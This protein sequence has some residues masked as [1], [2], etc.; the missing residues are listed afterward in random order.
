[1][2]IFG[3]ATSATSRSQLE[4]GFSF[5]RNHLNG[6]DKALIA[7][8]SW[9]RASSGYNDLSALFDEMA[10]D[11][12]PGLPGE[13]PMTIVVSAGN[14]GASN[15]LC[16]GN[17]IERT[18][19]EPAT[20]KNVIAVGATENYRPIG[21]AGQPPVGCG[22][23]CSVL[24][25]DATDIER[26]AH[27]SAKGV[28]FESYEAGDPPLNTPQ[29]AHNV[30]IKPDLV[31]P[32]VRIVSTVPYATP[33]TFNC[34]S[35]L[36]ETT[37]GYS[38][39]TF[40]SYGQ[41]TSF[42]APAVAGGAAL[43]RKWFLDRGTDAAPSLIKAALIATADDLCNPHQHNASLDCANGVGDHRPSN[44]HG[45]GRINVDT[46]TDPAVPRFWVNESAALAVSTGQQRSFTVTVDDEAKDVYVV[47]AWS[48]K[49]SMAG[50]G[51]QSGLI[52]DLRLAID[53]GNSSAFWRGNNFNENKGA[54]DDGY[55]H[56]FVVGGDPILEDQINTVEAVFI[57][58]GTFPPGRELTLQVT[59]ANISDGP[60]TFSLYAYNASE[61]NL[62]PI[63]D[64]DFLS[65][66]C[67]V[68]FF[69]VPYPDLVANDFDPDGDPLTACL[70]SQAT[71]GTVSPLI[72]RFRYVPD[73]A[74]WVYGEDSFTYRALD[75][76]GC[77]GNSNEATVTLTADCFGSGLE[78]FEDS[79]ESNDLT[80]W[81]GH[82]IPAAGELEVN[83]AAAMSGNL[84]L[85][86]KI[87]NGTV[88]AFVAH[89]TSH[90][91]NHYNAAFLIDPNSL[92]MTD[93]NSHA[94]FA[95]LAG[96]NGLFSIQL[97]MQRN[98][99]DYRLKL[100]T[101]DDAGSWTAI[102]SWVTLSDAPHAV[103]IEWWAADEPGD[104]D[105]GIRLWLDGILVGERLGLDNDEK[106]IGRERF[107]VLGVDPGTAGS[108]Y[109]DAFRS[110]Q[111]DRSRSMI[112]SENFDDGV[113]PWSTWIPNGGSIE[114]NAEAAIAGRYGMEVGLVPGSTHVIALDDAPQAERR[115]NTFFRFDPNSLPSQP[116]TIHI[117]FVASEQSGQGWTSILRLRRA[118]SGGALEIQAI[119]FFND[120][121]HTATPWAVISDDP[122]RLRLQWQ[123]GRGTANGFLRF[124]ID[125]Q[126]AGELTGLANSQKRVHRVWLG[127]SGGSDEGTVGS[128]FYD[129]FR[130]WR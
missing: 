75:V 24:A 26:V 5:S 50:T 130:A 34:P 54:G 127:D 105:G 88:H 123:A 17:P 104:D 126:L 55:S 113:L 122:H 52:N 29:Y 40:H 98:N 13:Q 37:L 68:P 8:H 102:P 32:G 22:A 72:G 2:K 69:R 74:F 114:V 31:A 46:L 62:P 63:A 100:D 57:P 36:C 97:R 7:N 21:A 45:W 128:F 18:V 59:G 9:N 83:Q 6:S 117:F 66:P 61:V 70:A 10:V 43:L 16:T 27:F 28:H 19:W 111:G 15:S 39:S 49:P 120:D 44:Y 78:T 1:M 20:A 51:S 11:A 38:P 125:G 64:D 99:G 56:R 82:W 77:P 65:V 90:V 23:W 42:A 93:G 80:A 76:P 103:R 107:G 84:G 115:F 121:T 35:A 81:D 92:Q 91:E 41:G 47:L 60:Q 101:W 112:T 79:F 3:C 129:D 33:S 110:W 12:N 109:L 124:W 73:P 25:Q 119:T 106:V 96:W 14:A 67:G 118:W 95:G 108:I 58:G 87:P 89:D 30:R 71:H 53:E 48:D 85:E 86:V 4:S 94:I 116:G